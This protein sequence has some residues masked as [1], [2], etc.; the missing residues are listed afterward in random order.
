MSPTHAHVS[1]SQVGGRGNDGVGGWGYAIRGRGGGKVSK[2]NKPSGSSGW[3]VV[4][5]GH[6]GGPSAT[7]SQGMR[8]CGGQTERARRMGTGGPAGPNGSAR[9]AIMCTQHTTHYYT[10]TGRLVSRRL[11]CMPPDT[12]ERIGIK[13]MP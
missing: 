9:S 7:T 13:P 8:A 2:R 1:F 6:G 3:P 11:Q 12:G 10:Y 4:A 5:H